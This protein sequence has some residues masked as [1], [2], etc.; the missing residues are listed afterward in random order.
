MM[1]G[2]CRQ[3]GTDQRNKNPIESELGMR[4]LDEW[5]WSHM[6]CSAMAFPLIVRAFDDREGSGSMGKT[7]FGDIN[8]RTHA[9]RI[10]I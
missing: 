5:E 4:R 10:R 6:P 9:T 3:N 8:T 1:N 2:G 7:R